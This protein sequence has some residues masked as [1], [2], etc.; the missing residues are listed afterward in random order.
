MEDHHVDRPS[1]EAQQ[2]VKLI[3]TNSPIDLI[4]P[5]RP[6][7]SSRRDEDQGHLDWPQAPARASARSGFAAKAASAVRPLTAVTCVMIRGS[8]AGDGGH[9]PLIA[10]PDARHRALRQRGRGRSA[11]ADVTRQDQSIIQQRPAALKPSGPGKRPLEA[12]EPF[13]IGR[14]G[15]YSG[16]A[17]PDPIPNSAV[18]RPSAYDTSSQDAGKS[19]AARSANRKSSS[20]QTSLPSS[21]N[22][23]HPHT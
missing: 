15:G 6:W 20:N 14:P 13:A 10:K 5:I 2:C 16:A 19:V 21:Q 22:S 1:V 3:G 17:A 8:P 7:S 9:D 12:F 4:V 23:P 18:K 11:P